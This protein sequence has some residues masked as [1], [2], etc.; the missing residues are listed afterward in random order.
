MTGPRLAFWKRKF[1]S[2]GLE[3]EWFDF[4]CALKVTVP[5][6]IECLD[7]TRIVYNENECYELHR[8]VR[9]GKCLQSGM[10]F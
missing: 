4:F 10:R 3:V 5:A 9:V 2:L 8:A 7:D 1:E 6:D